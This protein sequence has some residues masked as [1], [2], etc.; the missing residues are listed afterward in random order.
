MRPLSSWAPID[1]GNVAT[2]GSDQWNRG[3]SAGGYAKCL[4]EPWGFVAAVSFHRGQARVRRSRRVPVMKVG[5]VVERRPGSGGRASCQGGLY[6]TWALKSTGNNNSGVLATYV[7]SSRGGQLAKKTAAVQM[8]IREIGRSAHESPS[9]SASTD[10][11]CS[12]TLGAV[13]VPISPGPRSPDTGM[14]GGIIGRAAG[15]KHVALP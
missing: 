9:T 6:T 12:G 3:R 7:H 14:A 4:G 5:I 2:G 13:F 15:T 11:R 8:R 1:A 10:L